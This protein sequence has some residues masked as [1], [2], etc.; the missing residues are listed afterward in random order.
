MPFPC[1]GGWGDWQG[2]EGDGRALA[3]DRGPGEPG[4]APRGGWARG[5]DVPVPGAVLS[6][7]V[8]WQRAARR[9]CLVE[10]GSLPLPLEGLV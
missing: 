5:Q 7:A 8:P 2:R 4:C 9:W 1:E 3:S 10:E 6:P